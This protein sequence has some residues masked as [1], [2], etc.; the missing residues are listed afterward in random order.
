MVYNNKLIDF[1][2]RHNLYDD[3]MFNYFQDNSIMVDYRL[4][5]TRDMIGT[6]YIF[7]KNN[8][9]KSFYLAIPYLDDDITMLISIHE[10]VH[11]IMAYDRLN[12]SLVID[13]SC[14][15]LPMLY[16]KIFVLESKSQKASDF[17]NYLDSN[18]RCVEQ[19]ENGFILR[20]QLIDYYD[21]DF[22]KINKKAKKLLRKR[23]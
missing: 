8:K 3:D 20:E 18:I 16:E 23:V 9:L 11:A 12:K 19:Y 22:K 21:Y 7:G 10:I 15:I 6:Y 14:E 5:E 2:K 1:F 13:S 17:L 4:E